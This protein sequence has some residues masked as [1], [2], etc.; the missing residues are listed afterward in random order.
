MQNNNNNNAGIFNFDLLFK[1]PLDSILLI[2]GLAH[3]YCSIFKILKT[4]KSFKMHS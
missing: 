3:F 4:S 1:D 2:D